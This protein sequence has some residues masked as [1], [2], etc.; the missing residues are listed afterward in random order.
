MFEGT[1][2]LSTPELVGWNFDLSEAVGFDAIFTHS[3]QWSLALFL[4][5][6]DME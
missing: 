4:T 2:G 6:E 5:F 3:N 1:L